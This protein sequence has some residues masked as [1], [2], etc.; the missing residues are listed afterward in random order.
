[1]TTNL[2]VVVDTNVLVSGLIALKNSP[3]SKI[4]AAIQ[5]EKLILVTSPKIL[6]EI[7]NVINRHRISKK[8]NMNEDDRKFFIDGLVARSDVT[9]GKQL[10][11]NISRDIKDDKF[12]ACG[13][14][15]GANYI[16][17]GDRDLLDL[18]EYAGIDI[19]TPR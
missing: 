2:R 4:L 7:K 13:V 16:I 18:T 8:T 19:I 10:D 14:E 3:S 11:H 6:D 17:T 15:G 5:N 1:M 9:V 12:L